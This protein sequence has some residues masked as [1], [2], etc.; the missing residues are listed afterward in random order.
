MPARE[1]ERPAVS[2]TSRLVSTGRGCAVRSLRGELT[3]MSAR[4]ILAAAVL[5]VFGLF[6]A[7]G[8]AAAHDGLVSSTPADG[9]SVDESPDMVVLQFTGD[10]QSLGDANAMVVT[11]SAGEVV[12]TGATEVVGPFVRQPLR[13]DLPDGTYVG[14]YRIVS[15]DGHEVEGSIRFFVGPVPPAGAPFGLDQP[16]DSGV[17][18]PPLLIFAVG[19]VVLILVA[20]LVVRRSR[21]RS[22]M[23]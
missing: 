18:V 2:G 7:T 9:Q 12:S 21:G 5:A 19:A 16:P 4:R 8:V 17:G 23:P 11:D 10:P 14:A 13:A 1:P 3:V 22:E 15:S 6:A 20:L